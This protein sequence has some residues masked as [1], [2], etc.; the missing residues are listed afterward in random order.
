MPVDSLAAKP[1]S[2]L[3][4]DDDESVSRFIKDLLT[5]IGYAL[6][7]AATG[8]QALVLI[9]NQ[10]PDVIV[11]DLSM[12]SMDGVE[13]L[14]HL[15]AQYQQPLPFGVII[16]TGSAEEQ[17]FDDA[18]SLG[19]LDI[20]LKPVQPVQLL[21]AIRLQQQLLAQRPPGNTHPGPPPYTPEAEA[22]HG[23]QSPTVL[24]AE[25]DEQLAQLISDTLRAK[26]YRVLIAKDGEAAFRLVMTRDKEIDVLLT[27][28]MLPRI[29]GL[30]LM[31]LVQ[32]QSPKTQIVV[33]SGQLSS[34]ELATTGM[35]FL[36]KPF[37]FDHLL[38]TLG[39]LI[40]RT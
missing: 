13:V 35:T 10:P 21:A 37:S 25:D 29:S 18:M 15:Q 6:R 16:L 23:S 5:P 9:D 30:D 36:P 12:P 7:F 34:A 40:P 24:V 8:K 31:T 2:V 22:A 28:V 33:C 32:G 14:R 38:E 3:I 20:L 1:L 11:L 27:D 17:I 4:V 26:G 39:N 19:I